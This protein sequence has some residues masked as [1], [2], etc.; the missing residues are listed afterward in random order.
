MGR[1]NGKN[2]VNL[3]KQ[4]AR[5]NSR[6]FFLFGGQTKENNQGEITMRNLP[7]ALPSIAEKAL[8]NPVNRLS[9]LS[10]YRHT[11]SCTSGR[12]K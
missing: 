6:A 4:K 12:N 10:I 5:L 8:Q 11:H 2:G 9:A 3:G 7:S 1:K